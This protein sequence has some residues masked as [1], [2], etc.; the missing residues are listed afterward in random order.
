MDNLQIIARELGLQ[1]N[2]RGNKYL[3]NNGGYRNYLTGIDF[4]NLHRVTIHLAKKLQ[5]MKAEIDT[6]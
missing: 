5:E 2:K 4:D 1:I 6:E 3:V